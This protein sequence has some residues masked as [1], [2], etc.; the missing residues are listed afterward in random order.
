MKKVLYLI[1][2]CSLVMSCINRDHIDRLASF[3]GYAREIYN[4]YY[5][6]PLDFF[7][8]SEKNVEYRSPED[9]TITEGNPWICR[10]NE[11][12]RGGVITDVNLTVTKEGRSRLAVLEG[13]RTEEEGYCT[14]ISTLGEGIRD[15]VGIIRI[16]VYDASSAMLGWAEVNVKPNSNYWDTKIITGQ[17]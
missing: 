14:E 3:E 15:N 2:T 11:T 4:D 5:L 17:P 16:D 1:L 7:D 8:Y 6:R 12:A 13:T 10:I 9:Y